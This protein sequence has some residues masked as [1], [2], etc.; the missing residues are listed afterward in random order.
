MPVGEDKLANRRMITSELAVP[1]SDEIVGALAEIELRIS[2]KPRKIAWEIAV[3]DR[4][5]SPRWTALSKLSQRNV[6]LA[7]QE[8]VAR[9][10]QKVLH[11]RLGRRGDHLIISHLPACLAHRSAAERVIDDG[12]NELPAVAG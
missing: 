3:I 7:N 1:R 4:A 8:R 11:A 9:A 10:V 12:A 5:V 6:L 2:G